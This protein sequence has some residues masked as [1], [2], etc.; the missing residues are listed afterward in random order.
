MIAGGSYNEK[1]PPRLVDLLARRDPDLQTWKKDAK[2]FK[3][4]AGIQLP[5]ICFMI[6]E[7]YA[8]M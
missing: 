4:E 2:S 1:D 5:R 7:S 8:S 6:V 3:S